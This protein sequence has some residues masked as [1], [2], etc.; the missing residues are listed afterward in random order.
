MRNLT[1]FALLA[2]GAAVQATVIYGEGFETL[3]DG[4]PLASYNAWQANA[5][6]KATT[7]MAHSGSVSATRDYSLTTTGTGGDIWKVLNFASGGEVVVQTA[8]IKINQNVGSLSTNQLLQTSM[9]CYSF[10]SD[11]FTT[12]PNSFIGAMAQFSWQDVDGDDATRGR[13]WLGIPTTGTGYQHFSPT[14]RQTFAP[15][16]Q[17]N[18]IEFV[19][20][21]RTGFYSAKVN[22]RDIG[23]SY[24]WN[25]ASNPIGVYPKM[26]HGFMSVQPLRYK[27]S[28]AGFAADATATDHSPFF[29]D[30]S[31]ETKTPKPISGTIALEGFVGNP[32]GESQVQDVIVTIMDGSGN[33]LEEGTTTCN[34]SGAFDFSS[35]LADGTY[36]VSFK[37]YKWLSTGVAS[38]AVNAGGAAVGTVTLRAGDCDENN[39]VDVADFSILAAA[40]DG[41]LDDG[42]GMSSA[43]WNYNADC[44]CDGLIDIADYSLLAANFDGVGS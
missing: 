3:A 20:D 42:S 11:P 24:Q 18:K 41:V 44:N 6:V 25:T 5:N 1:L 34:S 35:T 8:W 10:D 13:C 28:G 14:Y 31:V 23:I 27:D 19:C 32:A 12:T 21:Y 37:S 2:V 43:N 33:V 29:D 26:D 40:F 22:G 16:G 39:L 36:N 38:V 9:R 4:T 7:S 17:W 15:M 30:Y